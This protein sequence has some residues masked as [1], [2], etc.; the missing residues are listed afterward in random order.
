MNEE[1]NS[2]ARS[3]TVELRSSSGTTEVSTTSGA[4]QRQ[5]GSRQRRVVGVKQFDIMQNLFSPPHKYRPKGVPLFASARWHGTL[6]EIICPES[7]GVIRTAISNGFVYE[8][9]ETPPPGQARSTASRLSEDFKSST[10]KPLPTRSYRPCGLPELYFNS[11]SLIKLFKNC[12]ALKGVKMKYSN[13]SSFASFR[14]FG[15][16][17]SKKN[18]FDGAKDREPSRTKNNYSMGTIRRGIV[19]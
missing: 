11:L 9:L 2:S 14:L 10:A 19:M 18:W 16:T 4:S 1:L 15:G 6:S 8:L 12:Q 3:L 17:E 5:T 13:K 7:H